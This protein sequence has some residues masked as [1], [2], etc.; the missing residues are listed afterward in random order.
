MSAKSTTP[1]TAFGAQ[2]GENI[3]LL[4]PEDI[5]LVTDKEHPLYDRRV[6]NAPQ[7]PLVA[8]IMTFGVKVPVIVRNEDGKALVVDGRQRVINAR[9]AN[10]RL[11]AEGSVPHKIKAMVE[12]R[13]STDIDSMGVMVLTNEHRSADEL[14]NKADKAF[15][16]LETGA[17]EKRVA[18]A[19][20]VTVNTLRS[21]L[22]LRGASAPVKKAVEAGIVSASAAAAIAKLPKAEQEKHLAKLQEAAPATGKRAGKVSARTAK[23]AVSGKPAITRPTAR[24]IERVLSYAHIAELDCTVE[25]ALNWALGTQ[26]AQE[27][28]GLTL[29]DMEESLRQTDKSDD[30]AATTA[31]AKEA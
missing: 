23:A 11:R 12:S 3:L 25:D 19:F 1:K 24:E 4:D 6:H 7:E 29:Q 13:G 16:M 9:E 21:W 27:V 30:T 8:S 20:G 15:R 28:F 18:T 2:R 31:V 17:D 26:T 10:K 22:T 5:V 14:M